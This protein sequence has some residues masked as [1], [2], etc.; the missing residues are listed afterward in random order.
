MRVSPY[1]LLVVAL[2]TLAGCGESKSVAEHPATAQDYVSMRDHI[3]QLREKLKAEG[4]VALV[5]NAAANERAPRIHSRYWV[6]KVCPDEDGR[7][8]YELSVR[9]FGLEFCR[10]L[11]K[12][13]L[14][15]IPQEDMNARESYANQLF[16]IADWLKT[17][18][19]YGN[20]ILKT[21]AE[22]LALS[23]VGSMAMNMACDTNRIVRLMSRVDESSYDLDFRMA[24]LNEESP[25]PFTRPQE[26]E[27]RLCGDNLRKQ[28]WERQKYALKM[29]PPVERLRSVYAYWP[30]VENEPVEYSFYFDDEADGWNVPCEKWWEWKHHRHL[31][32]S[33]SPIQLEYMLNNLLRY[34]TE[35]GYIPS[36]QNE[37]GSFKS[38]LEY[39]LEVE[40]GWWK[41]HP[42]GRPPV[43]KHAVY[44]IANGCFYDE[45]SYV[46][47]M[48]GC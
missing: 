45:H 46:L 15:E 11:E 32:V 3:V 30:D 6:E 22:G 5:A 41:V 48:E 20:Y 7:K 18:K 43:I 24:I 31:C 4:V 28:W 34:R 27:L 40:S 38:E 9:D 13:S 36:C 19:G 25:H 29:L 17:E 26:T 35:V 44:Q 1:L 12:V 8:E 16:A 23:V 2:L 33:W 14:P 39:S 47:D 37:D 10:Q 42:K 21:W